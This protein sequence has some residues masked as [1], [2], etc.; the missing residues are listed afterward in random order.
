MTGIIEYRHIHANSY[1]CSDRWKGFVW[2]GRQAY[3]VEIGALAATQGPRRFN[4]KTCGCGIEASIPWIA[5]A[6]VSFGYN[7]SSMCTAVLDLTHTLGNPKRMKTLGASY[8][9]QLLYC[10]VRRLNIIHS[11]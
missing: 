10:T 5:R 11:E 7:V 3:G 8:V 2:R 6:G 4:P 9:V 1:R